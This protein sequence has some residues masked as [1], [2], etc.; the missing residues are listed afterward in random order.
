[1][2]EKKTFP[3]PLSNGTQQNGTGRLYYPSQNDTESDEITLH[4][5]LEV[6]FKNKWII[7][8]SFVLV[9]AAAVLYTARQ[10]P[11]YEA[12]STVYVNPQQSN[13]AQLTE[14]LGLES[15]NRNVA[16]EIEIAKS[17]KIAMR[18]AEQL[19]DI[20]RVPGTD[21]MLTVIGAGDASSP[22]YTL[23]VAQNLQRF[24]KVQQVSRGVDIIELIATSTI[25]K[26]AALISEV[27][28][29]E[30]VEHNRMTSRA[31]MTASKDFLTDITDQF[32]LE[33][34]T[35]ENDLTRFFDEERLVAPDAEA[36][37]LI[38]QISELQQEQYEV[39][40]RLG[41]A[42]AEIQAL[43]AEIETI[44]PG[45]AD[46]ISS[47]DDLVVGRFVDEIA[48]REFQIEKKYAS[49]PALREDP[50]G[51]P[52]LVKDLE[53]LQA[54]RTELEQRSQELVDTVKP[55]FG[56]NSIDS[57]GKDPGG[58]A[59]AAV[60]KLQGQISEK[61]IEVSTLD[62]RSR[63]IEGQLRRSEA[64][65]GDIPRKEIILSR[66]E[67]SRDTR[68]R[69]YIALIEKLQESQ[70]AEQSELGYVE[71]VDEAI[72]PSLPV[73]PRVQLNLILATLFGLV[74]GISLAFVRNAFDNK[75]RKPEDLRKRGH[76]VV[77]IIPNMERVIR[78][79]FRGQ[80]Y[81]TIDNHE[82][83]TRLISLLNPLSPIA[84]GYRRVRTNIQYSHPD[85]EVRTIMI[86]SAGPG[87]GKTVTALNL[88]ITI[89][90]AGRRTLYIDADLR[91]PQG[92]R[93][94]GL[95][96]EPGLVDLLFDALP[97]NIEQFATDL[98]S[99]LYIIPAGRDVPNPA[100]V[101]GS[102]KMKTFL[103]RWKQEFDVILIDTPPTLLVADALIM[104]AECDVTLVICLAGETNWQAVDR[105][106]E[107]LDGVGADVI[108]TLL[109]SFD[110]K[111]A[112]GGYKYGYGY[113]YEYGY[114][115]YYYYGPSSPSKHARAT[116]KV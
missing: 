42:Q 110:A 88:A 78:T 66:L 34:Q 116:R 26:E 55:F 44:R 111:A 54:L 83:S 74:L 91:R 104:A 3:E 4:E 19:I 106:T 45:L 80:E 81:V 105:C 22:D 18:V 84:E 1:M 40:S 48:Q 21:R 11:E 7:L 35:A 20:E 27:W 25:P 47:G 89:A 108:G 9:L 13:N 94:M 95:P 72:V 112:Y 77:G 67:R 79:D 64:Q 31:R 102:R 69:L 8:A 17:R 37:Q 58:G 46:Q 61:K 107:A 76:S 70:I 93:M 92:H 41:M 57:E 43:E 53:E 15:S 99:Y 85:G 100:E 32:S 49:Y 10:D 39:R 65:L 73:R 115:N 30:Y 29:E 68:E 86:T 113:G 87:E 2:A 6:L 28:A 114:G 56:G 23:Q 101:L 75:V 59:L 52:A 71:I 82:C 36:R 38:T 12:K 16:N 51:D 98:D 60:G 62:V 90:Q 97:D 109:N 33:L 24:I 5:I 96:R 103:E 63:F 14:L 50:S